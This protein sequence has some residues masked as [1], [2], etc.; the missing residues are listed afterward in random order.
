VKLRTASLGLATLLVFGLAYQAGTIVT[1]RTTQNMPTPKNAAPAPDG[2]VYAVV[3]LCWEPAGTAKGSPHAV[4]G[5]LDRGE[6]NVS[7]GS[8]SKPWQRKGLVGE[9][10]RVALAW[11]MNAEA[12]ARVVRWRITL[13]NRQRMGGNE[14]AQHRLF[15]CVVGTPPCE[16]P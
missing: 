11:V 1:H 3:Q 13:N 9:G 16:L 15:A 8:C 14:T 6:T 4:L 5:P 2:R 7:I 10:N 12:P